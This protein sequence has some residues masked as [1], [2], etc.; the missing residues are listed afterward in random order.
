M[1]G[2]NKPAGQTATKHLSHRVLICH[3]AANSS[4]DH[5]CMCGLRNAMIMLLNTPEVCVIAI[6]EREQQLH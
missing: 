2:E 5:Y 6:H 1:A 4:D 3:Q